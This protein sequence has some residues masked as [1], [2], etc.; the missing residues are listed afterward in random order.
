MY[1]YLLIKR[2]YDGGAYICSSSYVYHKL[3]LGTKDWDNNFKKL[4]I[5]STLSL[6]FFN[7]TSDTKLSS[8]Y[9]LINMFET[10]EIVCLSKKTEISAR[11][12]WKFELA[13]LRA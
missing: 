8:L 2:Y 7:H 4:N 12:F 3:F 6:H 11:G 5:E 9:R 13:E 10:K 1:A